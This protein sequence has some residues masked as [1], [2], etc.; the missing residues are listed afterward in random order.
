MT[1]LLPLIV[2]LLLSACGRG[3]PVPPRESWAL[4]SIGGVPYPA[5]ATLGLG[6]DRYAGRGPCN[7]Y[8]GQL[9]REVARLAFGVPETGEAA[10]PA[11]AAER[12]YLAY[13]TDVRAQDVT[14][15]GSTLIL[16]TGSGV[17]LRFRPLTSGV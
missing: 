2:L 16:T 1:R 4:V 15:G 3:G 7:A 9:A 11:L 8:S 14:E 12:T 10:C 5:P 6:T 17:E 13:L